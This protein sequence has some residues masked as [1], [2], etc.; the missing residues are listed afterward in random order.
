MLYDGMDGTVTLELS[1]QARNFFQRRFDSGLVAEVRWLEH[2]LQR[3]RVPFFAA[4]PA[5]TAVI[6]PVFLVHDLHIRTALTDQVLFLVA[7]A[8]ERFRYLK[9]TE[10]HVQTLVAS[11]NEEIFRLVDRGQPV[12]EFQVYSRRLLESF[13]YLFKCSAHSRTKGEELREA[14]ELLNLSWLDVDHRLGLTVSQL[15]SIESGGATVD[16]ELYLE[17]LRR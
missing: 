1:E 10:G 5:N 16:Y 6:D 8:F 2:E 13:H 14:R 17:L 3:L 15:A 11:I 12:F 7:H 4:V 9:A